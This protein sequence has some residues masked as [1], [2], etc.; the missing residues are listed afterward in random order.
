MASE[1]DNLIV[2]TSS[3]FFVAYFFPVVYVTVFAKLPYTE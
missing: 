3:L 2:V 1:G